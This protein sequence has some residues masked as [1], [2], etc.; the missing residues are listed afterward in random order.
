MTGHLSLYETRDLRDL[1]GGLTA[2]STR[3]VL[4]M[5][6]IAN[7]LRILSDEGWRPPQRHVDLDDLADALWRTIRRRDDGR[8]GVDAIRLVNRVL[9]DRYRPDPPLAPPPAQEPDPRP[10]AYYVSVVRDGARLDYRLL[11]G[12]FAEHARALAAV[13]AVRLEADRLDP[14]AVWYAFGT[15]RVEGGAGPGSLNDRPAL[16]GLLDVRS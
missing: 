11:L 10:G 6:R 15:C 8:S 7:R 14:R 16:A 1:A 3:F 4:R 2:G 5:V 12:P 9:K 13:D